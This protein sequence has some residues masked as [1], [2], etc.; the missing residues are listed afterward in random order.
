MQVYYDADIIGYA[1]EDRGKVY[2]F[3]ASLALSEWHKRC[4]I[5]QTCRGCAE[6]LGKYF[7]NKAIEKEVKDFRFVKKAYGSWSLISDDHAIDLSRVADFHSLQGRTYD[8][9]IFDD[10]QDITEDYFRASLLWCRRDV[11][12]WDHMK[13]PDLT[14]IMPQAVLTMDIKKLKS[15]DWVYKYFEPWLSKKVPYGEIVPVIEGDDGSFVIADR[16]EPFI[17][18]NGEKV[19][20]FDREEVNP[21]EI[22][23]PQ[24]RTL[25]LE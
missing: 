3:I 25:I 23:R 2:E 5:V 4:E 15:S 22:V 7:L 6:D 11:Y 24:T 14:D 12:I 21:L 10:A 18:R 16:D 17:Y 9:K 13:N 8:L 1:S 20:D 19:Y